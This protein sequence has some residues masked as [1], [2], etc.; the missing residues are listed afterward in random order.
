L[1]GT[2]CPNALFYEVHYGGIPAIDPAEHRLLVHGM[3]DR[4]PLFT[5]DDVKR[6]P[7]V[8]VVHFLECSGNSW[9][10]WLEATSG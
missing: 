6:L 5:V 4:P 10:E 2:L 3:V 1:H 7:A 8:S 9:T